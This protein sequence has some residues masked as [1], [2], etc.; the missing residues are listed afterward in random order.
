[1][2]DIVG[3]GS[4]SYVQRAIHKPTGTPLALKVRA[5]LDGVHVV[6]SRSQ[7]RGGL[8][9]LNVLDKSK[10]DQLIKEIQALY[11]ANCDWFVLSV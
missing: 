5:A 7:A 3:R 1:M 6:F 10:R 4:S 8:Q 2:G 11:N 9:V